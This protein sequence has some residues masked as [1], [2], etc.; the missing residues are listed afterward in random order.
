MKSL[1]Y[2][3]KTGFVAGI[4]GGP[5][6]L[7]VDL[8][9]LIKQPESGKII[10][11]IAF[12]LLSAQDSSKKTGRALKSKHGVSI[13]G[14]YPPAKGVLQELENQFAYI[15]PRVELR[16]FFLHHYGLEGELF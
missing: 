8:K 16:A 7:S 3:E 15:I 9:F 5:V 13:P 6:F 14:M 10:C 2:T 1:P 11:R 4:C 12:I